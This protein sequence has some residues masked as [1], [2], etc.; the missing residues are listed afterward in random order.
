MIVQ[1]MTTGPFAAP[2]GTVTTIVVAVAETIVAK[3]FDW[4]TLV[5]PTFGRVA[6]FAPSSPVPVMVTCARSPP[7]TGML[8]GFSRVA[9]PGL[10]PPFGVTGWHGDVHLDAGGHDLDEG[11]ARG[12]R[13]CALGEVL[14]DEGSV[15]LEADLHADG[16]L[17]P[18]EHVDHVYIPVRR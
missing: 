2:F 4:L 16:A 7:V 5:K 17:D 10:H 9:V 13:C 1:I 15:A 14:G 6:P 12:G 11:D 8:V 3:I 18:L